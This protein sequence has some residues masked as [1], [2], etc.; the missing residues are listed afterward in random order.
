[1]NFGIA[2]GTH[3]L[4]VISI[5]RLIA[6]ASQQQ[7]TPLC[8][9]MG[10]IEFMSLESSRTTALLIRSTIELELLEEK[11]CNGTCFNVSP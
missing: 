3:P 4:V 10:R 11:F 7:N 1:M 8:I 5:D 9:S 2:F 6:A